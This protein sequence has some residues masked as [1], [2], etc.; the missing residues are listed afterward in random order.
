MPGF[1][2]YPDKLICCCKAMLISSSVVVIIRMQSCVVL[3]CK[4]AI[5]NVLKS[6]TGHAPKHPAGF[7]NVEKM[8]Q[9]MVLSPMEDV[10]KKK[11]R[12]FQDG[13][14]Q[15]YYRLKN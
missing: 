11:P 15:G 1:F 7:N 5:E 8:Q 10:L 12:P 6:K 13:A 2:Y 4:A 3:I 14:L 9:I